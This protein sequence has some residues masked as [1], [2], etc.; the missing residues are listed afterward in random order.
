MICICLMENTCF[1]AKRTKIKS[2][3]WAHSRP[4]KSVTVVFVVFAHILPARLEVLK[5]GMVSRLGFLV[6]SRLLGQLR[7]LLRSAS[8]LLLEISFGALT[9]VEYCKESWKERAPFDSWRIVRKREEHAA[10][11]L[12]LPQNCRHTRTFKAWAEPSNLRSRS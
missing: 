1:P 9:G 4:R 5:L 7:W 3:E 8:V 10:R 2:N 12:R 6:R 11:Q